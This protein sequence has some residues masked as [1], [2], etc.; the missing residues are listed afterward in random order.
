MGQP[1]D[2]QDGRHAD[3]DLEE[4]VAPI[5]FHRQ[6]SLAIFGMDAASNTVPIVLRPVS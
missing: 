4:A 3:R 1:R 6:A 5:R 2:E